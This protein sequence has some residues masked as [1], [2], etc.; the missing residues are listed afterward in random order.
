MEPRNAHITKHDLARL[1]ATD[2]GEPAIHPPELISLAESDWQIQSRPGKLVR[3]LGVARTAG[4]RVRTLCGVVPGQISPRLANP[5][6]PNPNRASGIKP[7]VS[8]LLRLALP[9]KLGPAVQIDAE[10]SPLDD[11]EKRME[12]ADLGAVENHVRPGI[13]A[14]D[15]K[16]AVELMGVNPLDH[17]ARALAF[18]GQRGPQAASITEQLERGLGHGRE[19]SSQQKEQIEPAAQTAERTPPFRPGFSRHNSTAPALVWQAMM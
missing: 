16:W 4:Q 8:S 9:A 1:G 17:P 19:R 15:R 10:N 3:V 7:A 6:R 14:N 2:Q 13:S 11:L 18:K 5:V 12:P